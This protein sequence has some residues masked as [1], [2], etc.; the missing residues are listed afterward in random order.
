VTEPAIHLAIDRTSRLPLWAQLLGD[1]RQ[2]LASGEF[3]ERFPTDKELVATYGV[4]RHTARE[5][6]RRLTAEGIVQRERGRGT[7]VISPEFEQPLG[8]LYSM[9]RS[10]ESQGVEQRSE[11]LALEVTRDATVAER[12]C[13]ADDAGLVFLERIR[14]AGGTPLALD[15]VWLPAAL[16]EP[17]LRADFT[18]TALYDELHSQCDIVLDRASE[19]IAPALADR[20]DCARLAI[21]RSQPC[22]A[23]ER[24][25]FRL[26]RPIE[27]RHTIIRGDRF[28]FVAEWSSSTSVGTVFRLTPE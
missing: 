10:I 17:L 2:R 11:V 20:S 5:A 21:D 24:L 6:V 7:T 25:G 19:R 18:H 13:L 14:L 9:F 28:A 23:I 4:S 15:R 1:L 27:W 12:L 3:G 22:F 8:A 16:A 26:D